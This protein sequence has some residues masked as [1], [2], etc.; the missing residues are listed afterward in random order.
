[1]RNKFSELINAGVASFNYKP[2][3]PEMP[4][5]DPI[6]KTYNN[7]YSMALDTHMSIVDGVRVITGHNIADEKKWNEFCY[8]H[9]WG[10]Y[11]FTT[12][13]VGSLQNYLYVT[14]FCTRVGKLNNDIVCFVEPIVCGEKERELKS[15][16][17]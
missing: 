16:N 6:C 13:G 11:D 12:A 17:E 14:G 9:K 10:E 15:T 2:L 4:E 7:I 1:M 3:A 5:T 8:S